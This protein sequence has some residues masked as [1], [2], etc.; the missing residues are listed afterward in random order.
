MECRFLPCHSLLILAFLMP[1]GAATEPDSAQAAFEQ[2]QQA[3]TRGD[4]SAA[5][6]NFRQVLAAEPNNVGAHGNLAVVYMRR[7]KWTSALVEL[8]AA[9][10]LAPKMPGIRLN[11]GL[12]YYRQADYRHAIAPFESVL[13]DGESRQA[14]YLLGLCYFF[15]E[16]YADA[17]RTLQPLWPQ[18]S[19]NLNYLYVV[20]IA[21]NMA[22]LVELDQQ[23]TA[24][25]IEVGQ[26]KAT[27]HLIIGK[28][29]LAHQ[30]YSRAIDEF[31]HAARLD[32]A[33]PFLH[34]FLGTIYRR[35]N[36]FEAAKQEFLRD[37][38]I[39]PD[40]PYD[41]DQLGAV[42]YALDQ[43][44]AAERYFKQAL[45]L[46]PG[47]GT[48]HY[49]LAKIYKQQNRYTE[50]LKAL[51]AAGTTDPQSASVHYLRGQVLFAMGRRAEAKPEFDEAA[52]LK[53]AIRD[54]LERTISGQHP[55]DPQLA[56]EDH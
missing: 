35:S 36:D 40:V 51:Q 53:Q 18:E 1:L 13:R 49:G 43:I 56:R 26:D 52:R 5:E 24:R 4:L 39:E 2:G 20:S 29:Y 45:R 30:D 46:D 34:Y 37:A 3:L 27:F 42:C 32:P 22:G 38:A 10:R 28:A 23:A 12:V 16:Q 54:E 21:A 9:E 14:R 47:M 33:L 19:E 48:S 41:Y 50:A 6:K 44:P 7:R 17:A 11:I 55:S 25:L 31:Q 15:T 8:R